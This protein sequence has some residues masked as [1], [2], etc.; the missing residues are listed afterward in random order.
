M[1]ANHSKPIDGM[2]VNNETRLDSYEV[3]GRKCRT[4]LELDAKAALRRYRQATN[5]ADRAFRA[6]KRAAGTATNIEQ[7]EAY[8]RYR[9]A[10]SACTAER[11]ALNMAVITLGYVPRA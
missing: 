8:N 10:Q 5:A 4:A 6:L 2:V 7:T 3:G 1:G 11:K 9:Q